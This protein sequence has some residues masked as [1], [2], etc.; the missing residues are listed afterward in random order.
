MGSPPVHGPVA[1][2]RAQVPAEIYDPQTI[3]LHWL[4]A[5]LV[6]LLWIIAQVIDDFPRGLPRVSA[7]SVHIVLGTLLAIVVTRRIWWRAA[8]G[9]RLAS[10]GPRWLSAATKSGHFLLYAALIMVLL[11]GLTNAWARGDSLFG[12]VS[13]P[14]LLP[15]QNQLKPTIEALHK[16]FANGL[17]IIAVLHSLVALLHHFYMKDQVLRRMLGR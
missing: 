16:Y 5:A 2:N 8:R 13:I 17:V 9:R 4:T 1:D 12:L 11:L 10:I 15:G 14:K 6:A 7:R 3:R